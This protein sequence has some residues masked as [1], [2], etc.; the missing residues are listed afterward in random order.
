[1]GFELSDH[2]IQ[3]KVILAGPDNRAPQSLSEDASQNR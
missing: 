2:P 1:M 3:P